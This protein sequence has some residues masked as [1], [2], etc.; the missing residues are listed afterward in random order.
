MLKDLR[1][2]EYK[3]EEEVWEGGELKGID[4]IRKTGYFHK[5]INES[6]IGQGYLEEFQIS[7]NYA[8]IEDEKG[9][10]L[11]LDPIKIKFII[12]KSSYQHL[13]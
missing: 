11:K 7:H 5:F 8:L 9:N 6:S 1:K 10:I 12:E 3:V 13:K 2:V 4:I